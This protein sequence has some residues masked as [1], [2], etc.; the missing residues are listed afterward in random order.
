MLFANNFLYLSNILTNTESVS[1]FPISERRK[2]SWIGIGR[3]LS[4]SYPYCADIGV[5]VDAYFESKGLIPTTCLSEISF[6]HH[7][8]FC[9]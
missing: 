9:V 2:F 7:A 6:R 4:A 8:F 1:L 3:H 5:G